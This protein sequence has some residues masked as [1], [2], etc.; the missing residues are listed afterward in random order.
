[1]RWRSPVTSARSSSGLL[2]GDEAMY[3]YMKKLGFGS[4]TGIDLAGESP[5]ILR[6]LARWQPSSI[7]SLAI[8][9]E[10]GVTALQMASAYCVLA[11]SGTWVK[12]HVVARVARA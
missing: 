3:D 9:Q 2:V 11:N 7:G 4:R 6:P 1:M 12:P 10:V 8:G 5:G